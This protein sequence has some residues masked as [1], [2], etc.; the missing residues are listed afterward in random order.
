MRC[1]EKALE[2]KVFVLYLSLTLLMN[3]KL[4]FYKVREQLTDVTG[5]PDDVPDMLRSLR[6]VCV[7]TRKSVD[8]HYL[9]WDM[10]PKKLRETL[11]G[12]NIQLPPRF[13]T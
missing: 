2:G 12:L 8:N 1:Q 3:L 9:Y 6:A 10:F 7:T 4:R 5:F 11:E 13:I